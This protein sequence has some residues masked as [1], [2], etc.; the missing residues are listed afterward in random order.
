MKHICFSLLQFLLKCV[1]ICTKIQ[2]GKKLHFGLAQA[3][4]NIKITACKYKWLSHRGRFP[5]FYQFKSMLRP[6]SLIY[7]SPYQV[8]PAW[9][10]AETIGNVK[11]QNVEE[12]RVGLQGCKGTR[13]LKNK[14]RW[15]RGLWATGHQHQRQEVVQLSQER[16][17]WRT[18]Q[19]KHLP[20]QWA[21]G[22][23]LPAS[24]R[25]VEIHV[26]PNSC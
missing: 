6:N 13:G 10:F 2:W 4:V 18:W 15:A 14:S 21:L 16:C 8:Y 20:A 9:Q 12:P 1:C 19:E 26:V 22:W 17:A 23:C 7:T 3:E 25:V 11:K 24:G 5:L